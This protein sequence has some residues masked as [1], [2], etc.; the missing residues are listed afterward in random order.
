MYADLIITVEG[1]MSHRAYVLGRP[2]RL[3]L[4]PHS[5]PYTW[6]PYGRN[7]QQTVVM[8]ISNKIE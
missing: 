5:Y 2:F 3:L 7:A 1:W 4:M 6:F 8:Q